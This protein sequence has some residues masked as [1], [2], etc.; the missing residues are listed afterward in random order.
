MIN[1][2]NIPAMD[3]HKVQAKKIKDII[4]KFLIQ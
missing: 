3:K 4:N 1:L 2:D